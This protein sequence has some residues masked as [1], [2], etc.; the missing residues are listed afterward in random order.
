MNEE[1]LDEEKI[2]ALNKDIR[3]DILERL[4]EEPDYPASIAKKIGISKQKTHYHFKKLKQSGLIEKVDSEDIE[5]G[6]AGIYSVKHQR[7]VYGDEPEKSDLLEK[8]FDS[9]EG[10]IVVGSPDQHGED[11]VRAR[12]GHLAGEIGLKLGRH[13]LNFDTVWDTEVVRDELFDENMVIIGG[14][15]TN[16]VT[17]KFNE[18]FPAY[19]SGESFP[20]REISTPENT[21]S[22]PDIGVIT[23]KENMILVAGIRNTGTRAAVKAFRKE[24]FEKDYLVVKGLDLDGDGEIDDYEVIE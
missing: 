7:L 23:R 6:K 22:D 14:I 18:D 4:R 1:K 20:Y 8:S 3:R 10:L 17:K 5:G 16:T 11:Q 13:H 21:Y 9:T 2:S 19:F 24:D 12:D 15:L